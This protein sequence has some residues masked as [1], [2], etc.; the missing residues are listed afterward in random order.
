MTAEAA[1]RLIFSGKTAAHI[2]DYLK[3]GK[4]GTAREIALAL[5]LSRGQSWNAL[6]RLRQAGVACVVQTV[7]SME[8]SWSP[9]DIWGLAAGHSPETC[10]RISS[11]SRPPALGIVERAIAARTDLELAWG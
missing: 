4:I 1:D 6:N 2:F 7:A 9:T 11:I 3:T 5:G 10:E 8:S